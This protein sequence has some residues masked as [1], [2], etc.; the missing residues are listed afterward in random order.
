MKNVLIIGG[1]SD[2]GFS[3]GQQFTKFGYNLILASKNLSNLE[4]KKKLIETNFKYKC[5]VY[6][7]DVE[8]DDIL[9]LFDKIDRDIDTIIFSNGYFERPEIN[10]YKIININYLSIVKICEDLVSNNKIENL[11]NII[12]FSSVAGDRGKKNNSI[13]SSAKAGL[14]AYANGL[15]QRLH[16]KKVNVMNV[17]IG[18]VKTKMTSNLNLPFLLCASKDDVAK[19]IYKSHLKNKTNIYVPA[20][21]KLI[22]FVYKLIPNFIFK[23]LN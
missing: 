9:S 23:I 2:I 1:N 7:F 4:H 15:N 16:K 13:Y 11:R 17:K 10:S 18:W 5:D 14:T 19:T 6:K 21:W 12:I 22:M 8:N 20:Y 3:L